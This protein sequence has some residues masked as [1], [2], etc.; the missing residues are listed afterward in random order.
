ME[1][2]EFLRAIQ[3]CRRRLNLAGFFRKLVSALGIGAVIGILL[4][5][6]SFVVPFYYAGTYAVLAWSRPRW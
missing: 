4:E 5:A 2:S 1:Q 6:V 3:N